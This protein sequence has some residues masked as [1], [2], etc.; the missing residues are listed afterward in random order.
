MP[1][2]NIV[3]WE[4]WEPYAAMRGL[5]IAVIL[6]ALIQGRRYLHMGAGRPGESLARLVQGLLCVE[7]GGITLLLSEQLAGLPVGR[8]PTTLG[9]TLLYLFLIA[10]PVVAV[11]VMKHWS[12]DERL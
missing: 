7:A 8:G 5:A 9:L 2:L 3:L 10:A 12:T 4:S 6:I 11:L 1:N